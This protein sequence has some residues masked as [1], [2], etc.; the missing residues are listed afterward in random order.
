M[1]G[2]SRTGKASVSPAGRRAVTAIKSLSFVLFQTGQEMSS[3]AVNTEP[4]GR[5]EKQPVGLMDSNKPGIE[6]ARFIHHFITF[7]FLK[8]DINKMQ[9]DI[10]SME[11]KIKMRSG[12]CEDVSEE[13]EDLS[14]LK[15]EIQKITAN[16]QVQN[17]MS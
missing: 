12:A 8:G 15:D 13:G 1:E 17:Q 6:L 7:Q 4:D 3:V 16:I 9:K 10:N 5:W 2:C 14:D 11:E